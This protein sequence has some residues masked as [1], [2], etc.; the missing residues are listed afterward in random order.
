MPTRTDS[1]RRSA[2]SLLLAVASLV[3]H[4]GGCS[5]RAPSGSAGAAEDARWVGTW[6]ASPQLT[7]EWNLPPAPGFAH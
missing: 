3:G 4:A 5:G 7:E 6:A 2:L 1:A